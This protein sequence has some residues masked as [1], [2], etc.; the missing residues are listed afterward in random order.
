MAEQ[1]NTE[2][3]KQLSLASCNQISIIVAG[4]GRR[5]GEP[6]GQHGSPSPCLPPAL[7]RAGTP[8]TQGC[9]AGWVPPLL[10]WVPQDGEQCGVLGEPGAG[11][12]PRGEVAPTLW[13]PRG[14]TEWVLPEGGG[15][16]TGDPD[17]GLGDRGCVIRVLPVRGG[18]R[19]H[20]AAPALGS[21]IAADMQFIT[22]AAQGNCYTNALAPQGERGKWDYMGRGR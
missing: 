6:G 18:G 20:R 21:E 17:A 14:G 10:P 19:W 15:S 8:S 2:P 7:R 12:E 3:D 1:P 11:T 9:P 22:A 16:I 13:A 4:S 5:E